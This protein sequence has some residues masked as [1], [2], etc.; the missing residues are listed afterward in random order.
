MA[1]HAELDSFMTPRDSD[2]NRI[3]KSKY[4]DT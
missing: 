1:D 2:G 4:L 3:P